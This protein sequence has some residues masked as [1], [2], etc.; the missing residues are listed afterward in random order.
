[1]AQYASDTDNTTTAKKLITSG[2][3][4]IAIL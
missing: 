3:R 1:M 2:K 4:F